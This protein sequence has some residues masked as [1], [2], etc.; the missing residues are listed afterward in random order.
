MPDRAA[1][2]ADRNGIPASGSVD[3]IL[4]RDDIDAVYISS[5]NEHHRAQTEL[6]AAA[7]KHVLCEKPLALS[8]DD[9]R[10]MIAACERAGVT[11]A[12]NHH[13][14]GSGIH[15]T[16]RHLVADGAVG[17][18]LGVR[19]FHAVMLPA[20]LQGWRLESR[21]GGGVTMD[22]TCHDASVLN[23]LLG[24]LPSDVVALAATQGPW[25][26]ATEDAVMSTLRYADGT[27]VQTHDAFT[28]PTLRPVSRCSALRAASKRWAPWSRIR[29]APSCSA[30]RAESARS[31]R[32]IGATCTRSM[33]PHSR[34]PCAAK[35]PRPRRA[36]TACVRSRSR[37][38]SARRPN[39]DVVCRSRSEADDASDAGRMVSEIAAVRS[40]DR[41]VTQAGSGSVA[42]DQ[43][44]QRTGLSVDRDAICRFLEQVPLDHATLQ[45]CERFDEQSRIWN[46][47]S[48]SHPYFELIFFIEG[49]ANIDAGA[50]TVNVYGFDVVI[51]PPGLLHAEHLELGRRQEIICFWVDTGPTPTFDHAIK[52]MDE[53]GTLRELFEMVVRGVHRQPPVC[54][55]ADLALPPGDLPPGAP[56]L[57]GAQ[58]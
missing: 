11:L 55:R 21:A 7:G 43:L 41:R 45:F 17:R 56:A 32:R 12:T 26:A 25:G 54:R 52:L 38:R 57:H 47:D 16:I 44:V 48:H 53:R 29:P 30:I 22:I 51:Y 35:A 46:F 37:W 39:P 20:R 18:V 49:K 8:V 50:E 27:L 33:S 2:F 40:T 9:G 28:T 42:A 3:E 4:A 19:V 34:P 15:R 5:T 36:S 6:A 14:P 10:A 31:S 23:P 1:S 58:P 24:A 13:L